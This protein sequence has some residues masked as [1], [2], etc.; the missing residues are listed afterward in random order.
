[1]PISNS[2]AETLLQ[3]A[4]QAA[5][6]AYAPYSHFPVGA[7][8]LT[9]DGEIITGVNVE[10]ASYGLTVCAERTAIVKAITLGKRQF[11]G[12]A[13]WASKRP[14]GSVTP[15]GGCR[16]FLAEFFSPDGVI[17]SSNATDGS[18]QC[19]TMKELLPEAFGPAVVPVDNCPDTD[20][21]RPGG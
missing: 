17:I 12:I 4:S 7:A 6:Q 18:V 2:M 11:L 20:S 5:E 16:Q 1:M 13:V 9:T 21:N 3:A 8:L 19:F 15:C 10:N 14:H